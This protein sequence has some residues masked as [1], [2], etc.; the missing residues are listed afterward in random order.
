MSKDVLRKRPSLTL[1][2]L[3]GIIVLLVLT[4]IGLIFKSHNTDLG[5][6]V[7]ITAQKEELLS[8]M[9]INLLKSA[10]IEK[11]AVMAE[12]DEL[13]RLLAD[14]SF[15]AADA[16]ETDLAVLR[17]IVQDERIKREE[18]LLRE[19]NGCW[20]DLRAVDKV[21]LEFAVENTNIKAS[22]LSFG[23]GS[24]ALERFERNLEEMMRKGGVQP[25]QDA[26][27]FGLV[28]E[29]LTAGFKIRYLQGPHIAAASDADMAGMEKEIVRLN[30]VV[31]HNLAA[32]GELAPEAS[33]ALLREAASAYADFEN[34]TAEVLKLSR[35]NTNVKSLELSLGRKRK[36]IAQCDEILTSLQNVVRDRSSEA[37]R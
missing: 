8:R 30:E 13:S 10:D 24:R 19:F 17:R 29:A 34:V 20:A 6:A 22:K 37:T 32:L 3:S 31:K 21:I 9:R 36:V 35:Q 27:V 15:K 11:S 14:E 25:D 33:R 5:G 16:V 2:I 26:R 28:S 4:I 12:T 7:Q 1:S 18:S 23:Q